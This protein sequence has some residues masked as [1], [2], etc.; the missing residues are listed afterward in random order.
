MRYSITNF[1]KSVLSN[2]IA[3]NLANVERIGKIKP[4]YQSVSESDRIVTIS[5]T[6]S[7]E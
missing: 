3:S 4:H 5:F 1:F 2:I 7:C 6:V